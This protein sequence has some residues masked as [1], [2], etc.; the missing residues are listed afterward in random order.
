MHVDRPRQPIE[1]SA[2]HQWPYRF[3]LIPFL[4]LSVLLSF[5][6]CAELDQLMGKQTAA[7]PLPAAQDKDQA[8]TQV[9]KKK[10]DESQPSAA[11]ST[12]TQEKALAEKKETKS[13]VAADKKPK[14]LPKSQTEPQPPT[15]DVFLSPVPL[16]TK[17]AAIGG[18]GG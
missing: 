3:R 18:S 17:P 11:S 1:C 9:T 14:K 4:G 16:P 15:E 10:A 2:Q 8:K 5:T 12:A 13:H 6:G 7:E